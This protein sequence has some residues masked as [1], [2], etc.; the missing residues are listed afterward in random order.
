MPKATPSRR[1][2][3]SDTS[4]VDSDSDV[5]AASAD[6]G[7]DAD[8]SD[9][10]ERKSHAAT[11]LR[12]VGVRQSDDDLLPRRVLLL[13]QGQVVAQQASTTAN[14]FIT[15]TTCARHRTATSST[16]SPQVFRHG[17]HDDPQR[18]GTLLP[19]CAAAR[20]GLPR[21]SLPPPSLVAQTWTRLREMAADR[22]LSDQNGRVGSWD[23]RQSSSN[24]RRNNHRS[25][26]AAAQ[27]E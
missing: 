11:C 16:P 23:A 15:D 14:D 13:Q 19:C 2:V 9:A 22:R 3:E 27:R 20:K 1:V 25:A 7:D 10:T 26:A 12:L 5:D 4:S 8:A 18:H 21:Y 17:H 24:C 6:C